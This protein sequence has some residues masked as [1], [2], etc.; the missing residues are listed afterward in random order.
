MILQTKTD[1]VLDP[2]VVRWF[3]AYT[4]PRHEKK[5]LELLKNREIE[6][7]VPLVK[8]VH[9][10]SDRK[11]LIEE[12]LIRSY[13][14]VHIPPKHQLY[15][16]ETEGIVHFVT[17]HKELA[18]IPDFQIEALKRTIESGMKLQSQTYLKTGQMVEVIDGP[19]Q[20]IIGHIQRIENE[21]KFVISLD[22]VQVAYEIQID[23]QHLKPITE[24]KKKVHI[25]LPLG[26]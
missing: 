16:V 19:L 6:A 15:V 7:Y 24:D 14:F 2:N 20:G 18:A 1:F 23:P 17:F 9:Q 11:K 4:R 26:F 25:S 13:V 12:P 5:V 21:S 8:E 10:W 22:A 3:A